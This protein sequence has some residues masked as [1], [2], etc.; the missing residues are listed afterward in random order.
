V[1]ILLTNDDGIEAQGIAALVAALSPHHEVWVVAPDSNRSGT[2]HSVCL[3]EASRLRRKGERRFSGSGSPADCVLVALL[4]VVPGPVDAV[5]S[6]VNHGPNLG[7]DIVYS[8]TAA[9]ARE[10]ALHGVPGI[11]L[12]LCRYEPPFDFE[13]AA[14]WVLVNLESLRSLWRPGCFANVNFPADCRGYRGT[15]MTVPCVR[16]YRDQ[17]SMFQGPRGDQY[18]FL[19]G[20]LP[21]AVA[22]EG[23][24]HDAV[25]RGCVSISLVD[26]QPGRSTRPPPSTDAFRP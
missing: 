11:A 9:A 22:E 5:I 23:S 25:S 20:E 6:G 4:G 2:S 15:V 16:T 10:A 13:A 19:A 3:H 8:G 21:L 14:A 7:T 18:C 24:D 1:R 26:T 17:L 12:S